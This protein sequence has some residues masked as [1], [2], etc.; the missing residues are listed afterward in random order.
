MGGDWGWG[1]YVMKEKPKRLKESLKAWNREQFGQIGEKIK[2]LKEELN[3]LDVKDD[4]GGLG[5]S[6]SIRRNVIMV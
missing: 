2:S 1:C 5:K 6:K 4:R 3:S